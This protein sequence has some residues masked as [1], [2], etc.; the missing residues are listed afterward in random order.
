LAIVYTSTSRQKLALNEYDLMIKMDP[1]NPEGYFGKSNLYV[2]LNNGDEVVSNAQKAID[3]YHKSNDPY[4]MDAIFILGIGYYLKGDKSE[5][6]K[7]LLQAQTMG[8][9]I[10]VELQDLIK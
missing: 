4:E 6:K 1:Q 5:A 3:L 2:A 10:P 7:Y 8:K 9:D